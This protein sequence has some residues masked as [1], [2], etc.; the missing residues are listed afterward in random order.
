MKGTAHLTIGVTIGAGYGII[1]EAEPLT[2][3]MFAVVGGISGLIPDLDTNGLA[4]NK[5][6]LSKK[7]IKMPMFLMG[8]I[9]LMYTMYQSYMNGHFDSEHLPRILVGLGMLGF[10]IIVTQRR[11]L[12]LTGVGVIIGGFA[13]DTT[14]WIILLGFY[15]VVA[16]FLP[17]RSY[18]HTI[19][20]IGYYVVIMYYAEIALNIEGLFIIGIIGY[21]SHLLADMKLLPMNRRGVKFFLP[22]WKKEF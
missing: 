3:A 7:M 18:T 15:I 16:S 22:V 8:L 12:S 2:I 4:S 10:S 6:S 20:G 14:I 13:M 11:M 5:I 19:L 21:T 17:H 1:T 9:V